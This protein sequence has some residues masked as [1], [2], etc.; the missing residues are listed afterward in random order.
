MA[1][2]MELE[3]LEDGTISVKTNKISPVNHVSA[4]QFIAEL[5]ELTGGTRTTQKRKVRHTHE[6]SRVTVKS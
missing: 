5:E 2:Q 3:I 1:D 6:R 4:D